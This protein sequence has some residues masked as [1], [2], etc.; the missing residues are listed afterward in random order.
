MIN[1][2]IIG[3]GMMANVIAKEITNGNQ[4]L[5]VYAVLSRTEQQA[6]L[7]GERYSIPSGRRYCEALDLFKDE[8]VEAVYIATPTSE[9]EH[10]LSLA[11]AYGKHVLLEKPIPT[12]LSALTLYEKA[13]VKDLVVLDATHCV[14]NVLMQTIHDIASEH[15]GRVENIEVKFC[16]PDCDTGS[17]TLNPALEPLGAMGDLGWYTARTLVEFIEDAFDV[18][19]YCVVN[20]QGAIVESRITG[21]SRAIA[22]TLFASCRGATASQHLFLGG[23]MGEVIIKDFVMPYWGSFV[24]GDIQRFSDITVRSGFKPFL[25]TKKEKIYFS[26]TQHGNMLLGFSLAI[27]SPQQR[28]LVRKSF[29]KAI[30]AALFLEVASAGAK[31]IVIKGGV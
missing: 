15:V 31:S 20:E 25:E 19:S 22:F 13:K 14:H 5:E 27:K 9:K 2:A 17:N 8:K 21:Y 7:F 11:I 29:E 18:S 1:L 23:S 24:Y 12:S 30:R 28:E 4:E 10:Y 16:W 3:T 26:G 6:F